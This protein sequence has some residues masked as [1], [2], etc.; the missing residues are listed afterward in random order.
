M[1]D[2]GLAPLGWISANALM[3]AFALVLDAIFGEPDWLWKRVPHPIVMIGRLIGWLDRTLNH[4]DDRPQKRRVAGLVSLLALLCI[5]SAPI[6]LLL[7][8][9]N[10]IWPP[11]ALL[12][13]VI[14]GA[15]FLAQRSLYEH[16]EAVRQPLADGDLP[17][18]RNALSMIVGRDTAELD[19]AGV[20]RA[21]IESLAENH[22]DGVI[23]PAFWF[24]IG[25]PIGIVLYKTINTADSMIAYRSERHLHFGWA[26]AKLDD[27]VNWVPAR[28]S[29]G[30]IA[31]GV[32][33]ARLLR[34]RAS[35]SVPSFAMV[36]RDA[37]THA[38]PNAGWPE[39]SYAGAL[40]IALGGPRTYRTGIVDA[41]YINDRGRKMLAADDMRV[42]LLLFHATC[43]V[44]TALVAL[45]A[46][47]GF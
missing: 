29:V 28:L 32:F 25:G 9:L 7:A 39:A 18:A 36:R 2:V 13:G 17:G 26:A 47:I 35:L 4:D 43:A 1:N 12:V 45:I 3:L 27:A 44:T 19:E 31:L 42:G 33:A 37:P 23:A 34:Y 10:A 30:L 15:V 24:L 11:L 6:L 38:S 14:L 8:V 22:S 5:V 20:A 41:P 46:V 40:G 16:V 21:G